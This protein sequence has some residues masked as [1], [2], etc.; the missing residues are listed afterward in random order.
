VLTAIGQSRPGV[1]GDA[2]QLFATLPPVPPDP[3]LPATPPL[4]LTPPLPPEPIAA[5]EPA[6]PAEPR[7]PPLEPALPSG[8][9][10][11]VLSSSEQADK[12]AMKQTKGTRR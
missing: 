12:T 3:R 9:P 1:G 11:G 7:A 2:G 4:P 10:R 6:E 8:S 5:P